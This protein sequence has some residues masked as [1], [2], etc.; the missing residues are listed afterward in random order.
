M[1]I[2]D[3]SNLIEAFNLFIKEIREFLNV[4]LLKQYGQNWS[5]KFCNSLNSKQQEGWKKSLRDGIQPKDIIDFNYLRPFAE[6]NIDLFFPHLKNNSYNLATWFA[7][8]NLVRNHVV[9]NTLSYI[10]DD[11]ITKAFI[12]MTY[13]TQNLEMI[14]I[15]ERIK[16]IRY[17]KKDLAQ[18]NVETASEK[19]REKKEVDEKKEVNSLVTK[20][21]TH[22][23]DFKNNEHLHNASRF[24][25]IFDELKLGE[26]DFKND[27]N[28]LSSNYLSKSIAVENNVIKIGS[29][30]KRIYVD[31]NNYTISGGVSDS[32][33]IS[34]N[35]RKVLNEY[36]DRFMND[37]KHIEMAPFVFKFVL[38]PTSDN[39]DYLELSIFLKSKE[40]TTQYSALLQHLYKDRDEVDMANYFRFCCSL[41]AYMCDL[42]NK[43]DQIEDVIRNTVFEYSENKIEIRIDNLN[44][45]YGYIV[46]CL[47]YDDDDMDMTWDEM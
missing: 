40:K 36:T 19:S 5:E 8:I 4:L 20:D 34:L 17:N 10:S 24:K 35:F 26:L 11:D 21:L 28:M 43:K 7:E 45:S 2:Y 37:Q 25:P 33:S 32:N 39:S 23:Q 30:E 44:L 6:K 47:E 38:F 41:L 13:I 27:F 18:K 42:K 12:H 9:H 22:E 14:E 3:E 1:S 16:A 31:F 46:R 15:A 29:N